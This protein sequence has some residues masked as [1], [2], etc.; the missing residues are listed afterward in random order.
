M[1]RGARQVGKSHLVRTWAARRFSRVVELNLERE[2]AIALCFADNDPRATLRRLEALARAPIPPDGSTL[3]FL[4]EIQ[5]DPSVLARLRWFAEELPA[6]PVIVAGSLL[7]FALKDP[8]FSMPVGRVT[9][10]HL[11]PMGFRE[12]LWALDEDELERSLDEDLA[13]ERLRARSGVVG[14]LHARLMDLFAQFLLVGGMPAAVERYRRDRSL[15]ASSEIQSDLLAA[16]RSDFSKYAAR[17]HH[18]RL[19]AVLASVA[20]QIGGKFRYSAADPEQRA[21]AIRQAVDLLCL[22]RVCHRVTATPATGAPLAAGA[23]ERRYKLILLDAGLLSALLGLSTTGLSPKADLMLANRGA[24]VEQAVGQLLRL[25]FRAHEEPSLFYWHREVRG[26]EAEIDY[27]IQQGAAVIPVE[28]KAGATGTLRSLH[29]FMAERG[30]PLAVRFNAAEP[31]ATMVAAATRSG[32]SRYELM[33]LPLYSVEMLP[34][35]VAEALSRP[36]G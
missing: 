10:M 13:V 21:A 3:L 33:S 29:M 17:V 27:V 30:F 18:G 28:V 12:F 6:L 25:C 20:R 32:P 4:D 14:P 31:S 24:L 26:A 15:L 35:L 34:R 7:D 1:L 16:L 19:N 11:E 5:S 2:P 9:F 36:P 8:S 22:A 23:D